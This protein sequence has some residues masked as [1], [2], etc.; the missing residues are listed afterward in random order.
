MA[1][2]CYV[3]DN[4]MQVMMCLCLMA[5][6]DPKH[7][8]QL[9]IYKQYYVVCIS[10]LQLTLLSLHYVV[11]SIETEIETEIEIEIEIEIQAIIILFQIL[12]PSQLEARCR[13]KQRQSVLLSLLYMKGTASQ[14]WPVQSLVQRQTM[15]L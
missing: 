5:Q 1:G 14:N 10:I 15:K 13:Q 6:L 3:I 8:Q 11:C 4:S 12:K 7:K 2:F 9:G